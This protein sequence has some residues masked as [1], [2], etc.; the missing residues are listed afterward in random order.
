MHTRILPLLTL[1]ALLAATSAAR[2]GMDFPDSP[3][4]T[5]SSDKTTTSPENNVKIHGE[6][7]NELVTASLDNLPAHDYV[8]ISVS[9]FILKS[10]DGVARTN[11]GARMGP[12]FFRLALDEGNGAS[13]TLILNSFSNTPVMSG[14]VPT[15]NYQGY[16]SPVPGEKVPYMTGADYK[17]MFGFIFPKEGNQPPITVHQDAVY[18]LKMT[19]PHT[20]GKVTLQFR[21]MGLQ[22]ISDE[23]WG[24]AGVT[25]T[26][27]TKAQFQPGVATDKD[28]YDTFTDGNGAEYKM[29]A[30]PSFPH[31]LELAAGHDAVPAN[32][33]FW[34]LVGAGEGTVSYLQDALRPI[35]MDTAKIKDLAAKVYEGAA[36]ADETDSRIQDILKLGLAAEPVLRDLRDDGK[37]SPARLDWALMEMNKL[38]PDDAQTRNRIVATRILE[39]I[40]TPEAKKARATLMGAAAK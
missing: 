31:L 36:P 3:N 29:L 33:A 38:T 14:F 27:R 1:A 39:A 35:N 12:D 24:V 4:L 26:P 2:A 20:A 13:R 37:E 10:W 40:G 19:L 17:N 30:A 5:W 9:L 34:K 11:G 23:S 22:E 8:Q 28:A 16:P 6:F 25:I 21:G 18:T 15:A 7:S 32:E